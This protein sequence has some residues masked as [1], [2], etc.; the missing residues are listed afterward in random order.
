MKRIVC[1]G[2][3][4]LLM[5]TFCACKKGKNETAENRSSALENAVAAGKIPEAEFG[6]GADPT[7]IIEILTE[8]SDNSELDAEGEPTQAFFVNEKN[9]YNIITCG[10]YQENAYYYK[11]NGKISCLFSLETAFGFPKMTV[12]S[13][14]KAAFPNCKA[15]ETDNVKAFFMRAGETC[16]CL[17]YTFGDR[18]V[19]F[20]FQ[21]SCLVATALYL[22]AE[23]AVG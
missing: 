18:A 14:I 12:I 13:E 19:T 10:D 5:L 17:T 22:T 7:E 16:D 4:V 23:W 15:I 21:E 1:F 11:E 8:R 2:L 6:L 20:A 3:A 9:G